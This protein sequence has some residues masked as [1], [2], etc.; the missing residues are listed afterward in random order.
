MVLQAEDWSLS[1]LL[2]YYQAAL[3][4][5]IETLVFIVIGHSYLQVYGFDTPTADRAV[6]IKI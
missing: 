4:D 2:M 5:S 3:A 1:I 6:F